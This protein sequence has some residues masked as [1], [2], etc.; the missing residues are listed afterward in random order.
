MKE[1]SQI[2]YS[3]FEMYLSHPLF[4]SSLSYSF[5]LNKYYLPWI[6]NLDMKPNYFEQ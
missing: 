2:F 4:F 3:I 6:C 1:P 5:Q